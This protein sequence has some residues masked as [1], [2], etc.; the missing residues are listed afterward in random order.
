[1]TQIT[2]TRQSSVCLR[3]SLLTCSVVIFICYLSQCMVSIASYI[4]YFLIFFTNVTKA[5][6][7]CLDLFLRLN[8][9]LCTCGKHKTSWT[10]GRTLGVSRVFAH[11]QKIWKAFS[12]ASQTKEKTEFV[13]SFCSL[14][15]MDCLL[16]SEYFGMLSAYF[17]NKYGS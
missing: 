16:T 2:T 10:S 7:L 3:C 8:Y 12:C 9:L 4:N 15:S 1:M 14:S 17:H 6:Q 13:S 5:T 11:Q